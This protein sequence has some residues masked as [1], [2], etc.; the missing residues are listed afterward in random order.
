MGEA[1][2]F[3]IFWNT[4]IPILYTEINQRTKVCVVGSILFGLF[5]FEKTNELKSQQTGYDKLRKQDQN[6]TYYYM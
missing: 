6:K 2:N 1:K 4:Y 5:D 3:K